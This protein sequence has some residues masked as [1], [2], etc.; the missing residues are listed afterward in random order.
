MSRRMMFWLAVRVTWGGGVDGGGGGDERFGASERAEGKLQTRCPPTHCRPRPYIIRSSSSNATNTAIATHRD[1]VRLDD[2]AQ[3]A[4]GL[5][6]EAPVLDVDADKEL[7]VALF[8]GG[9]GW[10]GVCTRYVGA[11]GGGVVT[12]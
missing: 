8:G 3:R 10:M 1:A 4:L 9:R 7:A 12:M 2:A 11:G 5:P 6:L